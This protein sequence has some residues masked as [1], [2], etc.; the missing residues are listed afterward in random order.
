MLEL[1]YKVYPLPNSNLVLPDHLKNTFSVS[2]SEYSFF[3]IDM[4]QNLLLLPYKAY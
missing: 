2:K 3:P 4:V 1:R